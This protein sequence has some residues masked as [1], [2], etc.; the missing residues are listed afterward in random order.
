MTGWP[1]GAVSYI[2]C[3]H[4]GRPAV[5]LRRTFVENDPWPCASDAFRDDG[6]QLYDGQY[7]E[8]QHCRRRTGF[9]LRDMVVK[10]AGDD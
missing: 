9:D 5:W 10:G 1:D 4:C 6:Q 8:C 2:R 3:P 7:A